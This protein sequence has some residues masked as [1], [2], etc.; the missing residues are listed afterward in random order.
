MIFTVE[1]D[2][3]FYK[4][5]HEQEFYW[6]EIVRNGMTAYMQMACTYCQKPLDVNESLSA[7][8]TGD[9]RHPYLD[10]M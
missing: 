1:N 4:R 9:W 2:I 3:S 6:P 8:D 7:Q 10:F 5:L